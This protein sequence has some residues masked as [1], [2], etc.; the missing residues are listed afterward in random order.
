MKKVVFGSLLALATSTLIPVPG[1]LAR[2]AAQDQAP[3]GG[4]ITIKDPA[5]YNA[6]SNAVG[7]SAPAAKAAAL[8]AFL[9]QYP[10]SV[11]KLDVLNQLL[12]AYQAANDTTNMLK[13]AK[14]VLDADPNNLRAAF[15][16][17]F[18][19]K[20]QATQKAATDPAGAQPMFDDAAKVADAALKVTA[21]SPG[22]GISQAD[23]QKLKAA[24]TPIFYSAI[25]TDDVGKKDY[26]DAIDQFQAEL[27]SYSDPNQTTSGP[28]LNDTYLLGNAYVQ[29]DPKN[30]DDQKQAIFYLERAAQYAPAASKDGIEKQAEY[31]YQK[32][33]GNMDGFDPIKQMAHD[34]LTPP[35][36][37]NPTP[38]P[39]P[40]SPE[41]LAHQAL[42]P[43]NGP[44]TDPKSLALTDKEFVLANG[45]QADAD[46][47]WN[48]MKG[49]RTEV[50]GV[51]IQGTTSSVQLA[52]SQ[53]AQQSKTA[54]FTVNFTKPLAA[55]PAVGASVKYIATFDSYTKNPLMIIMNEGEAPAEHKAPVHRRPAH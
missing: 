10:N 31:W 7:Q 27:K 20:T 28:G 8:E 18:L 51:V 6:Y 54:D 33:H 36:S 3:Q 11:A 44:P 53:D 13:T 47:V 45:N 2:A 1:L 9:Q 24:T 40:P 23:F 55:A 34:N 12:A 30:P 21:P 26:K 16:Y 29:E 50:P 5:E 22:S 52:V 42:F 19:T 14:R 32:Y 25:A 37:Y 41:T 4:S 48:V 46:A 17:V 15:I 43:P 49:V 39:P 35:A 38:A